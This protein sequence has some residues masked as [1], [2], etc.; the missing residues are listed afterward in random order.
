VS[1]VV[2]AVNGEEFTVGRIGSVRMA[3]PFGLEFEP[4]APSGNCRSRQQT[5]KRVPNVAFHG[6]DV[7]SEW[8]E[9]TFRRDEGGTESSHD[10][11]SENSLSTDTRT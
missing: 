3:W 4:R 2:P 7:C 11:V 6:E 5:Q 1:S 8:R 9:C 10:A